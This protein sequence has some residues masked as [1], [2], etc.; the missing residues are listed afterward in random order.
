M[1]GESDPLLAAVL[2]RGGR[3]QPPAADGSL[4]FEC[5]ECGRHNAWYNPATGRWNCGT[6]RCV[7]RADKGDLA[8]RLKLPW[9]NGAATSTEP[10][11]AVATI[12]TTAGN[13]ADELERERQRIGFTYTDEQEH[14]YT[15]FDMAGGGEDGLINLARRL[16]AD[17]VPAER[18]LPRL[19]GC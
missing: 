14:D 16:F 15:T 18:V 17:G 6:P 3:L 5:P 2:E 13:G 12:A 8:R 4:C 10:P 9:G 19:A 11:E 7:E 1:T